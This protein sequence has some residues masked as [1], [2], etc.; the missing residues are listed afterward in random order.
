MSTWAPSEYKPIR[1]LEDLFGIELESHDKLKLDDIDFGSSDYLDSQQSE[2]MKVAADSF[3]HSI[4]TSAINDC[5][6][7][8]S[9][10]NDL[11]DNQIPNACSTMLNG[12]DLEIL[13]ISSGSVSV[14]RKRRNTL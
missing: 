1:S 14:S 11:M 3:T 10:E 5:L 7:D 2:G 12:T 9:Y 4:Q 6:C 8:K 13:N